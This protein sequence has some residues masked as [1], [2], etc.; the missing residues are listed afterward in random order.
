MLVGQVGERLVATPLQRGAGVIMSLVRA[1]GIVRL[2]RFSEGEHA[3]AAVTVELFRPP[4][5]CATPLSVSAAT[6]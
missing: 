1:D 2:P 4:E 3:G 6:T 5:A